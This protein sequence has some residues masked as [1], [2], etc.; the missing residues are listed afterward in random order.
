[1]APSLDFFMGFMC[2]GL[3]GLLYL[4]YQ[5]IQILREFLILVSEEMKNGSVDE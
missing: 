5:L 1:M 3:V 4:L 2:C